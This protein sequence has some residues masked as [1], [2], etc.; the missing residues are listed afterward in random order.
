MSEASA[1][2]R[3]PWWKGK[4]G[5]WYVVVQVLVILLAVF[6]PRT[7]PGWPEWGQP[8]SQVATIAGIVLMV[9]GGALALG[10]MVRLGPNLTPLPYPRDCSKLVETGPYTF[11]RHP[12]YSGVFFGAV[13]WALLVHGW[14]TLVYALLAF[15]FVDIKSRRE[16]KWLQEKFGQSYAD[17]RRRVHKLIPWVY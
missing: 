1:S 10:G 16:E 8:Y 17:Y 6:G 7:F 11:V 2:P 9:L 4:R 14:L 5:E 12:I 13:G 3:A 15:V